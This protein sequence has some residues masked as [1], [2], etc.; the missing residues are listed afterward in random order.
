MSVLVGK[1]A[2]DFTTQAVLADGTIVDDF[3][4][5]KTIAGKYA[6]VFFYPMD[7]TFVCPS[8]LIAMS[9]RVDKLKE[10]GVEVIALSIDSH[11]THNAWRNT[12][13]NKGGIGEVKYPLAADMDHSIAQAYDIQSDGGDSYY[14]SGVAMRATFVIDQK[15]IVRHQVVNDEPLGRNMDELVRIVEALQFFEKYGQV[16]P[17]GW[18]KGDSGMV[19]TPE[20]V[21]SYLADNEDKL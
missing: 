13:V 19:N 18:N 20:G 17:A 14:P 2:P 5:S 21:A 12:E 11:H 8:K 15:G 6:V 3:S 16:C 10:L 9:H 4:L 1:K 7:F